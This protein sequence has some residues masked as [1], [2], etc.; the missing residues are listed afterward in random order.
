MLWQLSG[1]TGYHIQA[2]DGRCGKIADFLVS[3]SNW[4]VRWIVDDIGSWMHPRKVL[5][6]PAACRGLEENS[7]ICPTFL[8]RERIENA[9]DIS[10]DPPVALQKIRSN[11]LAESIPGLA[12][13]PV[14][15]AG[16]L[17]PPLQAAASSHNG[18][19]FDPHLRSIA[20]VTGYHVQATDGA[21]GEVDDFIMDDEGW[22]ISHLVVRWSNWWNHYFAAVPISAV[23]TIDWDTERVRLS[24][25]IQDIKISPPLEHMNVSGGNRSRIHPT[26]WESAI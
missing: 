12:Y 22:R 14:D 17:L 5:L 24:V 13:L 21:L 25:S 18:I 4:R 3:E 8:S 9:P 2:T 15:L 19:K 7:H 16:L 26:G 11:L 6:S 1:L 23:R 20:E 10:L